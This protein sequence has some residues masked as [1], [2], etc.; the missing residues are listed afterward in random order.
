M[1]QKFIKCRADYL[2]PVPLHLFSER[3]YNQS[4]EL[5]EGMSDFWG[6]EIID[7]ALWTRDVPRR[8]TSKIRTDITYE[9]LIDDVC[10]SGM[11][12]S[13]LAEACKRDG[14]KVICAYTLA[15]V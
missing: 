14:A 1:A 6:V 3:K 11:T 4:R 8:A 9:D 10:T 7:C 12:I 13:C 2:V 5:A 15:S